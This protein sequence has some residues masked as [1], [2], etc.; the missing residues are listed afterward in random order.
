LYDY[1][2]EL[3]LACLDAW[4]GVLQAFSAEV[5]AADAAA[6]AAQARAATVLGSAHGGALVPTMLRVVSAWTTA[7]KAARDAVA[8]GG[9]GGVAD[10]DGELACKCVGL[11][12]DLVQTFGI[13]FLRPSVTPLVAL[14]VWLFDACH[15][16][17][18]TEMEKNPAET[19]A[20]L[21]KLRL[22]FRA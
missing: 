11:V 6:R 4:T 15:E 19:V 10:F 8:A 5:D 20:T 21:A 1:L 2:H 14:L 16:W 9:G 22:G 13:D 12:V 18:V 17:E 3:R 7:W